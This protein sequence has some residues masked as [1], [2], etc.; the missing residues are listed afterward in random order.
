MSQCYLENSQWNFEPIN[1]EREN[2]DLQ[3]PLFDL[4]T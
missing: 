1:I 4:P 2:K 3:L